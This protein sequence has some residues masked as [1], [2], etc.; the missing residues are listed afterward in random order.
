MLAALTISDHASSGS[1]GTAAATVD[2]ATTLN[3]NQTTPGISLTLPTP[4]DSTGGRLLYVSN[5]GTE[6]FQTSNI[7]GACLGGCISY[8]QGT[9]EGCCTIEHRKVVASGDDSITV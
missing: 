6:Q 3:V 9:S 2:I 4:T 8:V 1:I 5:V 7:Q